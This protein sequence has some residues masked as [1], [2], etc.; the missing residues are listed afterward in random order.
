MTRPLKSIDTFPYITEYL[1]LSQIRYSGNTNWNWELGKRIIL[2]ATSGSSGFEHSLED[3]KKSAGSAAI[4]EGA[5]IHG[6]KSVDEWKKL[7][8]D[9]RK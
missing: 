9:L 2:F 5:V 8:A 4:E 3:L 1:L 7:L 6:K